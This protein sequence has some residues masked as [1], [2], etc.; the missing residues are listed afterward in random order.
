MGRG[1]THGYASLRGVGRRNNHRLCLSEGCGKRE[2][3]P[4]YASLR[5]VEEGEL[6]CLCLPEGVEKGELTP[7]YASLRGV[8]GGIYPYI[9]LP[10]G[11]RKRD[12]PLYMPPCVPWVV[13]P[14]IYASCI[15]RVG[16]P[17]VYMPYVHC[18]EHDIGGYT[19][20]YVQ[21]W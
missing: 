19:A 9:C 18:P 12:I 6:T 15:P 1:I 11:C 8:G 5:G 21:V 3:P 4:V 14:C 7:V 16:T 20:R 13:Y 2:L 10:E 17:A